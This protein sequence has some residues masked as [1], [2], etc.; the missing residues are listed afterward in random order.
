MDAAVAKPENNYLPQGW[1]GALAGMMSLVR[2]LPADKYDKL[3][4]D[5]KAG[6]I[7]PAQTSGGMNMDHMNMPGMDMN[8]PGMQMDH[9]KMNMPGM[10]M[11]HSKM[12]MP[13]MQMDHSK[14]NMPGM[15]MDHSKMNMPGM[16]MDHGK[17]NM[18]A[19][20]MDHSKMN[21]PG[22]KMDHGKTGGNKQ[23][24]QAKKKEQPK[25]APMT[26]EEMMNQNPKMK[27]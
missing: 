26:M 20:K 21:M 6:H 19:T 25:K 23:K 27:M 4:A 3:M 1:S 12:N 22:M 8:M 7:D 15:Q 2:V 16:Q 13:G 9:G 18:P 17:M 24:A 10:Q 11:D 5:I 14:M